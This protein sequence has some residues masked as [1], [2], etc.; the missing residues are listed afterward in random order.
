MLKC[1]LDSGKY[2]W[3]RK[4]GRIILLSLC[5]IIHNETSQRKRFGWICCIHWPRTNIS[6]LAVNSILKPKLNWKINEIRRQ[7]ELET[8]LF[9]CIFLHVFF[10]KI[11]SKEGQVGYYFAK[12][13]VLSV[14][15][16]IVGNRIGDLN[17]NLTCRCFVIHFTL[18]PLGK[19][20][21]RVF[22]TANYDWIVGQTGF[23]SLWL[24]NQSRKSK[25]QNSNHLYS[26]LK[27]WTCHILPMAEGFG[28]YIFSKG[29]WWYQIKMW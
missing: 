17:S 6:S 24:G 26:A 16:I 7:L 25:T 22:S 12:G 15:I 19:M 11:H 5:L 20:W 18:T 9:F 21:I 10:S 4:L 8:F 29:L 13:E 28:I 23:F 1:L 2:F 14:T 27:N 3:F